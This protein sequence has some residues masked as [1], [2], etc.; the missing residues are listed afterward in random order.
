MCGTVLLTFK[1][2][3]L[4]LVKAENRPE[5][6]VMKFTRPDVIG[7]R[8]HLAAEKAEILYAAFHEAPENRQRRREHLSL[9]GNREDGDKSGPPNNAVLTKKKRRSIR[10]MR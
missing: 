4:V 10:T 5:N 9:T 3:P 8:K 1:Y 7:P 6:E 2:R